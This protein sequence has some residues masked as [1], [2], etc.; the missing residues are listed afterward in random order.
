[1]NY[2]AIFSGEG[3]PTRDLINRIETQT[4]VKLTKSAPNQ[5][6]HVITGTPEAITAFMGGL[7]KWRYEPHYPDAAPAAR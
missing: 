1:M 6:S 3:A 4:A 5:L 7:S 2:I